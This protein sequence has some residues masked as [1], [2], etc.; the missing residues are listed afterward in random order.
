MSIADRPKIEGWSYSQ[1]VDDPKPCADGTFR[2]HQI[3]TATQPEY[4]GKVTV[5]T[6][7]DSKRRTIVN[8]ESPEIIRMFNSAFNAWADTS[9]DFYP[10]GLRDEIDGMN[11]FVY[12]H[13]NNSV[14][15]TGFAKTQGT[16]DEAVR[17]VFYVLDT[18]EE[19]LAECRYLVGERISEAG[20]NSV[21]HE[22]LYA[23]HGFGVDVHHL[24]RHPL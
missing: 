16:Y 11:N 7:W 17:K 21:T 4:T 12:E 3:Y 1:G 19:R 9:F 20:R 23:F 22:H 2:L 5:P 24:C 15:R 14:Y 13:L 8:N 10:E 6:L 18:L